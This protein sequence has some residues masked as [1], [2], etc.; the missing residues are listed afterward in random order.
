MFGWNWRLIGWIGQEYRHTGFCLQSGS[1]FSKMSLK[2]VGLTPKTI[3]RNPRNN[4]KTNCKPPPFYSENLPSITLNYR[5]TIPKSN[6]SKGINRKLPLLLLSR[7]KF[8]WWTVWFLWKHF[9]MEKNHTEKKKEK[10]LVLM[11]VST[12]NAGFCSYCNNRLTV[13]SFDTA[14][15]QQCDCAIHD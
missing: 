6:H 12:F 13:N 8:W 3:P 11:K 4:G 15:Y 7:S 14:C 1:F 5:E 10:V 2:S 9:I